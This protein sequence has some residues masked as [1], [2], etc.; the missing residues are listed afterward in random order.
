[1]ASRKRRRSTLRFLWKRKVFILLVLLLAG[2]GWSS[3]VA[4]KAVD[5]YT[6]SV[7]ELEQKLNEVDF[8]KDP[9]GW[10]KLQRQLDTQKLEPM[11][12]GLLILMLCAF[13]AVL[14]SSIIFARGSSREQ[15]SSDVWMPKMR[16]KREDFLRRN[17]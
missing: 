16:Q 5:T 11:L 10:T 3:H 7:A 12:Y 17:S 14:I 4:I 8:S 13:G 6:K 1:M 15:V 2:I 9:A